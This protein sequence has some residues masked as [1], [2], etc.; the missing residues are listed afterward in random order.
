MF[1]F[2]LKL[3]VLLGAAGMLWGLK[4]GWPST[5]LTQN[6]DQSDAVAVSKVM[7]EDVGPDVND[8]LLLQVN[9]FGP[10]KK[11]DLR[12]IMAENH[13]FLRKMVTES[14]RFI[15]S[16]DTRSDLPEHTKSYNIL[17][18]AGTIY[19]MSAYEKKHGRGE[20]VSDIKK[21]IDYMMEDAIIKL[22]HLQTYGIKEP[23]ENQENIEVKLGG[24]GLATVAILSADPL[25]SVREHQGIIRGLG[26]MMLYMQK[27]D[28]SFYSK[29]DVKTG[30]NTAFNSLYYPGEAALGLTM[31]YQYDH[32]Q[33]WRDG[34][35]KALSHLA[36]KRKGKTQIEEDH[37]AL[38]ATS[39]LLLIL[40]NENYDSTTIR[41]LYVHGC[42]IAG[43]MVKNAR[44]NII[45]NHLAGCFTKDGRT[46]PTA[47][48]LEGLSAM[49][50]IIPD[51]DPL[52]AQIKTCLDYG[53]RFLLNAPLRT[54]PHKGAFMS[55]SLQFIPGEGQEAPKNSSKTTEFRIDYNQHA[56]SALMA[57]HELYNF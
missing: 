28:G 43:I 21:A 22:D 51:E 42:Q 40:K 11:E 50:S 8:S 2:F 53:T 10:I 27:P 4:S 18:H 30:F 38:I 24:L 16:F 47:T 57:Y 31:L 54:G 17:R 12:T 20:G 34:A 49:Y 37:W 33:Q 44:K 13:Q 19:A 14:G 26:K 45:K 55:T 46:T 52:K 56:L 36:E 41:L 15:Y 7:T 25:I 32:Q 29:F 35:V 1:R 23:V 5:E 9:K 6:A 3:G 48:R 39:K